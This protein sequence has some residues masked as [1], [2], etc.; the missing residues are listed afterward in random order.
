MTKKDV[1]FAKQINLSDMQEETSG[2]LAQT[3]TKTLHE[4]VQSNLY[5]ALAEQSMDAFMVHD[6][7]CRFVEVNQQSCNALGYTKDEIL[8]MLVTDIEMDVEL[9]T[10]LEKFRRI[11]PG[12]SFTSQGHHRRK[13]GTLF[14]VDVRFICAQIDNQKL[15]L[16]F[17]RDLSDKQN[18]ASQILLA[19][20]QLEDSESKFRAV[21]E[22]ANV[23][24]SITLIT[25]EMFVNQAFS[26]MLGYSREELQ[27]KS[28]KEITPA[29][30]I[31]W[32]E[33]LMKP[34]N[35]GEVNSMRVTK[36]YVRKD[37]SFVWTDLS[38]AIKRDSEGNALFYIATIIDISERVKAEQQLD[39]LNHQLELKVKERTMQLETANQELEAFNYSVS[40]DLRSPLRKINGYVSILH[41]MYT[42]VLDDRGQ[43][44]LENIRKNVAR[45]DQLI[46]DLLNLS[47]VSRI[48]LNIEQINMH[49]L[50][51]M[52]FHETA[53]DQEV[54]QFEFVLNEIPS[55][56]GDLSLVSQVWHNLISNALKYSSKSAVKRIEIYAIESKSMITYCVKDC[57]AGFD[58]KYRDK[59]FK[60]FQRLHSN[61][62]FKGNGIGLTIVQQIVHRH[63]GKVYAHG[64]LGKGAEFRFSLPK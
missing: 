49:E 64:T 43:Q 57:G 17:V 15:F 51:E 21:F 36:R 1:S 35:R 4:I 60:A 10:L 42:G 32:L 7:A 53:T 25:G 37:G 16:G 3:K 22:S 5:H 34:L 18:A 30:D 20:K 44:F 26:D 45:M 31:G 38:S 50:A 13:D 41:S 28:W 55:I 33:E 27:D 6:D 11:Q 63:G 12:E 40:H 23:G 29:E 9:E 24:K 61:E 14:P 39:L 52:T 46:T 59:L 48:A 2:V 19:Q 56:K 8:S 47:Q 54:E 62:E 58:K